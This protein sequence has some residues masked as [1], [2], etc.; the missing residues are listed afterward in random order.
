MY[1]LAYFRHRNSST[2][3]RGET[4]TSCLASAFCSAYVQY[5]R[6]F[7]LRRNRKNS[8]RVRTPFVAFLEI[9]D[10]K[11]FKAALR[12]KVAHRITT[13][14]TVQ[15]REFQLRDHK[16]Q[17]NKT[18]LPNGGLNV[19]FTNSGVLKLV[20]GANLSDPSYAAGANLFPGVRR[21]AG[22]CRSSC[23]R[24][25]ENETNRK[26]IILPP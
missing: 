11:T 15:L 3:A 20:P 4:A 25:T 21:N 6:G 12:R 19:G 10:A 8:R 5:M 26:T 1:S 17:G 13:S 7:Q 22:R 24:A 16:N 23:W 18:V 9:K 2:G 14:R